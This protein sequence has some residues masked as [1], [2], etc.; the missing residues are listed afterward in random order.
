MV[1]E[2]GAS[3]EAPSLS[4]EH[5]EQTASGEATGYRGPAGVS[6]HTVE[7]VELF[8]LLEANPRDWNRRL[9]V[10]CAGWIL[11][12]QQEGKLDGH[13]QVTE[14]QRGYSGR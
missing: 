7:I 2:E 14:K 10:V 13:F 8:N 6:I 4:R 3:P 11:H 1:R 12:L 5:L 9:R